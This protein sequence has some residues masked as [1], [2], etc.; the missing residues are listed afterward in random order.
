MGRQHD[1]MTGN[2]NERAITKKAPDRCVNTEQGEQ[3]VRF[4]ATRI[5]KFVFMKRRA[6]NTE[7]AGQGERADGKK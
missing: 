6:R 5:G 2:I 3:I 7:H 4:L 1:K